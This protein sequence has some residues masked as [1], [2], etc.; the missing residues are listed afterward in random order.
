MPTKVTICTRPVCDV[1]GQPATN[2]A[3]DILEIE[4]VKDSE[5]RLWACWEGVGEWHYGCEAHPAESTISGPTAPRALSG[6]A[7]H[8]P[9]V[10][11]ETGQDYPLP[12]LGE[13]KEET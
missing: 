10:V 11:A 9:F 8:K 5:G 2:E 6:M 3:R 12:K 1:C 13:W 7:W 4:P